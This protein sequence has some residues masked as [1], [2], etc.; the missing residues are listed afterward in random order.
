MSRLVLDFRV[1][2]EYKKEDVADIVRTICNQVNALS[3]GRIEARYSS[4]TAAPSGSAISYTKGDF[5]W[6][7][8]PTVTGSVAP[9]VAASYVRLGWIC[10]A[11]GSPGTFQEMRVLTGA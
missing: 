9:G 11:P 8:N 3:E 6:D 10:V 2:V 7:S 1:P 5:V 4:H